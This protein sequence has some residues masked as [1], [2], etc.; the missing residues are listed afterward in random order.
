MTS[1]KAACVIL[2]MRAS[3]RA[4]GLSDDVPSE[5]L[6]Q[7]YQTSWMRPL[8][9]QFTKQIERDAKFTVRRAFLPY[10]V[11]IWPEQNLA[12]ILGRDYKPLGMPRKQRYDYAAFAQHYPDMQHTALLA[13]STGEPRHI[14]DDGP[15]T[16]RIWLCHDSG[17]YWSPHKDA[18]RVAAVVA[19]YDEQRAKLEAALGR[20]QRKPDLKPD[21]KGNQ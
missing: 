2:H 6:L 3:L 1:E 21:L 17:G 18:D 12:T 15:G 10:S 11:V 5:R 9:K 8:A 20:P 4:I 16:F 7:L 19:S 13:L 14:P